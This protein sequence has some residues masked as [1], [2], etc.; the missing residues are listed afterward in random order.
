MPATFLTL[1]AREFAC[2]D[3]C[4]NLLLFLFSPSCDNNLQLAAASSASFLVAIQWVK[5][6]R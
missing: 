5:G 4:S 6:T 1:S 2:R 3:F